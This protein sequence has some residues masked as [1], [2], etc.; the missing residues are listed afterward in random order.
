MD[1]WNLAVDLEAPGFTF[2]PLA[3]MV[4]MDGFALR[5]GHPD[6]S[7]RGGP[8]G[9]SGGSVGS[10]ERSVRRLVA[11]VLI[12]ESVHGWVAFGGGPEKRR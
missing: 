6:V 1:L 12:D 7:C 2:F 11:L 5:F 9:G 8:L 3:T 10:L 4:G